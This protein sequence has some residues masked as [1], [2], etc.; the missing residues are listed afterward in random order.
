MLLIFCYSYE[1]QAACLS[2]TTYIYYRNI[3]YVFRH[4]NHA[5]ISLLKNC[6]KLSCNTVQWKFSILRFE[7]CYKHLFNKLGC[8]S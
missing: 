5:I 8:P 1:N 6:S 4:S 3:S 2:D 7:T